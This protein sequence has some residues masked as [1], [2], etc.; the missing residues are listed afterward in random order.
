MRQ[1]DRLAK[2]RVVVQLDFTAGSLL[3]RIHNT[4]VKGAGVYMQAYR[5]F[6][7]LAWVVNAMYRFLGV[8]CT[9]VIG[10]HFDGVGGL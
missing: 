9:R 5:P 10:I 2:F 4:T 8:H 1:F 6:I 7:E 3:G